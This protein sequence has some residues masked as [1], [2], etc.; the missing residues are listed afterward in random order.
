MNENIE[1][2]QDFMPGDTCFGCGP[3]NPHGL[4]IRSYWDGEIAKCVWSP[5]P[6]HEGWANLTC[7]GVIAT[8]VDCHCINTAMA[9]AV[10][11]EKRALGSEPSYLFATGSINLRFL[12]PS[13]VDQPIELQAHVTAIKNEKKYSLSCDVF[14]NGE[15]TADAQVIALLVYRSDR[16]EEAAPAFKN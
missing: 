1:Y 3:A 9:T 12:K 15:K 4:K 13:P 5:Q 14:V 11:N 10:R 8:L 6:Y 16:P 7:G 2:F